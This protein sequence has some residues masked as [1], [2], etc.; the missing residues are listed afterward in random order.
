MFGKH[1]IS[2]TLRACKFYSSISRLSTIETFQ[3]WN[4]FPPLWHVNQRNTR[5]CSTRPVKSYY[6]HENNF[7]FNVLNSTPTADNVSLSA[8]EQIILDEVT[9]TSYLNK[10]W[11]SSNAS[12]IVR[13]FK[14]VKQFCIEHN[15]SFDDPRFDSL[16][17]GLMDHCEH[18]TDHELLDLLKCMA[19]YPVC[20]AFNSHNYHDM[21]SCL[22][23]ICCWKMPTWD[24][25]TLFAF[26][27]AWYK[28][29]LGKLCD[30]VFETLN[31]LVKKAD[32]LSKDQLVHIFFLFN[33]CR[34]RPVDFE[35]ENALKYKINE[36]NIDELAVVALGFFKTQSKIKLESI[37]GCM[38]QEVTSKA[39]GIHEISLTAIMKILRFSFPSRFLPEINK[40][41]DCLYPELDRFSDLACLHIA[42]LCTGLHTCHGNILRYVFHLKL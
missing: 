22:D 34:K 41:M 9:F 37:M 31:R 19:E 33:T 8:N 28:L 26:S 40:M 16:V 6:E 32:N 30:F 13:A 12:D 17:D 4:R 27:N 38:I 2:N 1:I 35:Y 18:L 15:I 23:D 21:W 39:L 5:F 42:L 7:L 3:Q 20:T 29:K 10:D 36:M 25:N 14:T 24:V 11:R